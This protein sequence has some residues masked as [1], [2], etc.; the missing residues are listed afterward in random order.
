MLMGE[1]V[2]EREVVGTSTGNLSRKGGRGSVSMEMMVA[3]GDKAEEAG[4]RRKGPM[5]M[6]LHPLL[7]SWGYPGEMGG[8]SSTSE[9]FPSPP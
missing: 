2:G 1:C 7:P 9:L 8:H 3:G 6:G 5:M 4:P